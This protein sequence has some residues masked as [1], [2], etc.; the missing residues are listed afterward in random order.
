MICLKYIPLSAV[1]IFF[2]DVEVRRSDASYVVAVLAFKTA[3]KFELTRRQNDKRIM[4]IHVKMNDM[5][6]VLLLYV[7]LAC[8]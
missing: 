8:A 2:D 6:S 3:L 7:L 1:R 5:L 4:L